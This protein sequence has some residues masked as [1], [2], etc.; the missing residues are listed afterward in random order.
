MEMA[1]IPPGTF[2]MGDEG[3]S[4]EGLQ[5]AQPVHQVTISKGFYLVSMR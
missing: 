1:Y 3:L 5:V 4:I 2:M